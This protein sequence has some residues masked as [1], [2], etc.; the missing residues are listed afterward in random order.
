MIIV[1]GVLLNNF[2]KNKQT[3]IIE[4]EIVKKTFTDEILSSVDF[5]CK[6]GFEVITSKA[7]ELCK[8][9]GFIEAYKIRGTVAPASCSTLQ[10]LFDTE[11]GEEISLKYTCYKI[12]EIGEI[13]QM[14]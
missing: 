2:F 8:A 10:D 4:N 5:Q 12:K 1:G 11:I 9:R 14:Y 7:D 3:K 6:F 13:D